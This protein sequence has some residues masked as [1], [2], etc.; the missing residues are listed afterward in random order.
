MSTLKQRKTA[1]AEGAAT[2]APHAPDQ[3]VE[4]DAAPAKKEQA[5]KAAGA[6]KTWLQFLGEHPEICLTLVCTLLCAVT[7]WYLS[8]DDGKPRLFDP[9]ALKLY[10]GKKN[11]PM[12]LAILGSV[13]DVT[14]G[15]KKYDGEK[16][17]GFFIGKDATRAFITG[18]F[19]ND[20]ND[21][22]KEYIFKGY[23]VGAFYNQDGKP[24]R[25]LRRAEEQAV[26]AKSE[27]EAM[28]EIERQWPAC[29]VRWSEAE[30]GTVWCDGGAYP[31][32]LFGQLPGG[33]PTTRCA[34]FKELGW[35]DLRQ[36]YPGC[37]P[38]ATTCKVEQEKTKA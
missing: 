4:K 18:D 26:K 28:A 17:Y 36:V 22:I 19:K 15:R 35:S 16:G 8:R 20:L 29:N 32:K 3:P 24:N 30:G 11:A 37:A 31:R 5:Q 21:Q 10:D 23:V 34:C 25:I 33:K 6:Q 38:D 14:K 13:F 2:P 7:L 9:E 12:Y 27:E 1:A